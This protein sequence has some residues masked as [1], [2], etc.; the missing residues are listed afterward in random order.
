MPDEGVEWGRFEGTQDGLSN[1]LSGM[2]TLE[3][4]SFTTAFRILRHSRNLN[5]FVIPDQRDV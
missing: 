2:S 5:G 3:N 1:D 4:D